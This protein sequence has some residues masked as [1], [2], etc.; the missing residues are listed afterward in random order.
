M[1]VRPGL[2]VSA[3]V[4]LF[5]F[6]FVDPFA[7]GLNWKRLAFCTCGRTK[8]TGGV[9][10]DRRRASRRVYRGPLDRAARRRNLRNNRKPKARVTLHTVT[11]SKCYCARRSI[12]K[13]PP[14]SPLFTKIHAR[15]HNKILYSAVRA[16]GAN[17]PRLAHSP[18]GAVS[19]VHK[20][21]SL[22]SPGHV[23]IR[24]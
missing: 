1:F 10:V 4:F 14:P 21:P 13:N 11:M 24:I 2:C 18:P 15:I 12:H 17:T 6:F 16:T 22:P 23:H 3:I 19:R 5:F 9:V 8:H 7:F 20:K